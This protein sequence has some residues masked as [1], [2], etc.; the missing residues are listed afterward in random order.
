MFIYFFLSLYR[1]PD[2]IIS[3]NDN[4]ILLFS[5]TNFYLPMPKNHSKIGFIRIKDHMCRQYFPSTTFPDLIWHPNIH[6]Y[7][8]I[9]YL[10]RT[11]NQDIHYKHTYSAFITRTINLVITI[12]TH[13]EGV[14]K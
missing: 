14:A 1:F 12:K 7:S 5:C 6:F 9:R 10:V 13:G 4:H 3:I 8:I 11:T 2:I